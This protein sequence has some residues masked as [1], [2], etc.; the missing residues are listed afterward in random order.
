MIM[1]LERK[2]TLYKEV[3]GKFWENEAKGMLDEVNIECPYGTSSRESGSIIINCR[4]TELAKRDQ[5]VMGT[6]PT[7]LQH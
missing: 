7:V 6:K 5:E 2:L 3:L 4:R 1:S